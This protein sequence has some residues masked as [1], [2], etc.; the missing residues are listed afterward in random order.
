MYKIIYHTLKGT[1]GW[2]NLQL[3]TVDINKVI[4]IGYS[5][6]LF[7]IFDR[8]YPYNL[9]IKYENIHNNSIITPTVILGG[10]IGLT[11]SFYTETSSIITKRY[12]SQKD[13]LDEIKAIQYK[14]KNMRMVLSK[15]F[16]T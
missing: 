5:K 8:D 2:S 6:R 13:V 3:Q 10:G 7:M 16:K 14:H 1:N 15:L 4:E 11:Q 9:I 12:K